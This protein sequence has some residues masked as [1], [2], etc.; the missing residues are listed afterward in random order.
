MAE[1]AFAFQAL[2]ERRSGHRGQQSEHGD[3]YA[4]IEDKPVQA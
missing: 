1:A 3:L 4:G 2:V